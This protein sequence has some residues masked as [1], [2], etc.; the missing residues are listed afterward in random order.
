MSYESCLAMYAMRLNGRRFLRAPA[1]TTADPE[2][3]VDRKGNINEYY[4]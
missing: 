4:V 1:C 2:R 3:N